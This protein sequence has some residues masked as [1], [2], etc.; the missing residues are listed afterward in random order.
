[1]VRGCSAR[2][3][4][5]LPPVAAASSMCSPSLPRRRASHPPL[6]VC[7]RVCAWCRFL[8]MGWIPPIQIAIAVATL[9][10][11]LGAACFVGLPSLA[12]MAPIQSW[13]TMCASRFTKQINTA[14]DRR[15][16]LINEIVAGIRVIKC[17][18]FRSSR[19]ADGGSRAGRCGV[20]SSTASSSRVSSTR[21]RPRSC[22]RAR[23]SSRC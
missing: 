1:M 22:S 23:S 6:R 17:F 7:V 11:Q 14:G 12:L 4:A 18:A 2:R 16:L 5:S 10:Q 9:Y 15:L 19:G 13:L 8:H 3:Q 21:C 20:T